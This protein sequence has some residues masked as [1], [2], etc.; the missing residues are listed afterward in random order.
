M[1]DVLASAKATVQWL[2]E[3]LGSFVPGGLAVHCKHFL[4]NTSACRLT[5]NLRTSLES[6][7]PVEDYEAALHQRDNFSPGFQWPARTDNVYA[8]HYSVANE[9]TR[10]RPFGWIPWA[11]AL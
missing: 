1:K 3:I 8:G 2:L 10:K 5:L 11:V 7:Q 4:V 6:A 9:R